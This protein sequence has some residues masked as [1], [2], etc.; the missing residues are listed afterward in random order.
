[1]NRKSIIAL[2]LAV[3]SWLPMSAG[4][5]QDPDM[6]ALL[7]AQIGSDRQAVV[8]LNMDLSEQQ[9]EKFWPLYLKYH[10][11]RDGLVDKRVAL[12]I[13]FRDNQI[14]MTAD[15]AKQILYDALDYE[16][17][18]NDLK[19]NYVSKFEKVLGPRHTLRYYQIEN[20]LDTLV[21]YELASVVPLR[22]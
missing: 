5:Q 2:V 9:A 8:A 19:H 14:G 6:I 13:E 18:I 1:M 20:K 22:Q 7:R 21:N 16:D 3:A 12:L 15:Q 4:A 17:K 11:A 10:E